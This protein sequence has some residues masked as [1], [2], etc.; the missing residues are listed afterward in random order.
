MKILSILFLFFTLTTVSTKQNSNVV[1]F[2]CLEGTSD[3]CTGWADA[4]EQPGESINVWN[5]R[6]N[7]CVTKRGCAHLKLPISQ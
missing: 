3:Y 6:Y 4:K 7:D 2:E 5:K 1:L